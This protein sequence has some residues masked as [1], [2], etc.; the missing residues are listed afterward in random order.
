MSRGK[1]GWA[2]GAVCLVAEMIASAQDMR[3]PL[4]VAVDSRGVIYVA[5][6]DLPGVWRFAEGKLSVY[7]QAQKTF[8]TPLNRVR[9]LAIDREGKLLAGDSATREVYRLQG[10]A[11]PQPLTN[12]GVGIPMCLAVAAD[13]TIYASDLEIHRL[14]RFPAAGGEV[15]V[16]AEV[17]AV[18]GMAFDQ[19]GRLWVASHGSDAIL[20]F[21]PDF[22]HREVVVPGRVFQFSHHL[23]FADDGTAYVADGYAKTIWKVSGATPQ[24]LHQGAPF[25]NPVGLTWSTQHGLLVA[26]PHQKAVYRLPLGGNP[27]QLIPPLNP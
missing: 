27:E 26:D 14:V 2:V 1:S 16:V 8:R 10:D 6:L 18:R 12:A 13:G 24:P 20:R 7:F 3:Y 21:S 22:Q 15:E 17:P 25:K 11:A 23:T 4:A 9:C 5:D 19:E